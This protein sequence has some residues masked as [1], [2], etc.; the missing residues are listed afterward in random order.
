MSDVPAEYRFARPESKEDIDRERVDSLYD[1]RMELKEWIR[2]ARKKAQLT[3]DQLAESLGMTKGNVSAWE[4]GRHEPSYAQLQ[5]ISALADFAMPHVQ[6][7]AA[8]TTRARKGSHAALPHPRAPHEK[9]NV[10][11]G[12][13]LK[14]TYPLISWVQAGAW[15]QI[16]D[17]FAPGDAEEWLD[18]PVRASEHSFYLRVR[19]ESMYD[20]ADHKSFR[21]GE[22][23][24]VDPNCDAENG[25]FVVVRLDDNSEATFKQLIIEGDRKYLKALNPTWPNRI[26]EVNGNATICGVVRTKVVRY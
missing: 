16:V 14:G 24:L 6:E 8:R 23:V 21:D 15:R 26:F 5:Q 7:A 2:A 20:P 4:N 12:P 10:E 1:P 19:G 11:P 25:S 22:I 18:S 9:G 3:Q 17:N 13:D